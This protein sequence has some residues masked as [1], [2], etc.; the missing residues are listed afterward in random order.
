MR[1][2]NT[3]EKSLSPGKPLAKSIELG[4]TDSLKIILTTQEGKT[5]KK[6]HQAS[7]LL[8]DSASNLDAS[9]PLSIKESGKAKV[10]LVCGRKRLV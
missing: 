6:P 10:D 4:P 5:A 1:K 9:Y 7:L 3:D 8:R 2:S